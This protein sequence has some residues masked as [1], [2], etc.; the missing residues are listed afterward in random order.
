MS[1][2]IEGCFYLNLVNKFK[3]KTQFQHD[4][5]SSKTKIREEQLNDVTEY[6]GRGNRREK[7]KA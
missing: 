2:I 4:K 1:C 3:K 6:R 5:T 7:R